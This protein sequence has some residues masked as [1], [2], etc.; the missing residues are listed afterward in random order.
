[1][2]SKKME[3]VSVKETKSYMFSF[4]VHFHNVMVANISELSVTRSKFVFSDNGVS[5][6]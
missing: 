3:P 5:E 6:E 1:M 4:L 2:V